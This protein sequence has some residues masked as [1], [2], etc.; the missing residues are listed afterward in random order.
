MDKQLKQFND[1]R[2]VM[3]LSINVENTKKLSSYV[4]EDDAFLKDYIKNK[5]Y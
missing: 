3:P 2:I 4:N 5:L 1:N